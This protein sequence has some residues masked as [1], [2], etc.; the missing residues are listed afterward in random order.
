MRKI[1]LGILGCGTIGKGVAEF[2]R[3]NKDMKNRI[4]IRCLYDKRKREPLALKSSLGLEAEI[5]SSVEELI[6]KCDCILETASQAAAERLVRLSWSK[7]KKLIIVSSGVFLRKP[8]LARQIQN[9]LLTV[10][11]PSG[12]VAG[13]DGVKAHALGGIKSIEIITSKPPSGLAR[14]TSGVIFEGSASEA[15][16]LFPHNINVASTLELAS[17]FSKIRVKIR[18]SPRL[19]A[20]L[21]YIKLTSHIGRLKVKVENA[22]SPNPRTSRLAIFSVISLLESMVS[23][24]KVGS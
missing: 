16:K 13:I 8:K 9:S 19:K 2:V 22:P 5:C 23:A 1:R 12:A 6:N 15:V 11:V 3:K 21:H 14:G 4:E 17:K 18:V 7:K 20:N 24:L 10:Y